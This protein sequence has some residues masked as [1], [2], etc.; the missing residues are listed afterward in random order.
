[1]VFKILGHAVPVEQAF[2]AAL[3]LYVKLSLAAKV[4]SFSAM[5]VMLDM[6]L[7]LSLPRE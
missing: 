3:E 7:K 5:R 2:L 6:G 4:R 1:M